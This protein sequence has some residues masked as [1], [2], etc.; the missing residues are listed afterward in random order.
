MRALAEGWPGRRLRAAGCCTTALGPPDGAARQAQQP[1]GT[2]L[3]RRRGRRA[4]LVP[5][6]AE[7]P[8][9]QPARRAG[10]VSPVERHRSAAR[11]GL[12]AGAAAR[13][14]PVPVRP[15]RAVR[16]GS[17]AGADRPVAAGESTAPPDHECLV[18]P[19]QVAILRS[20]AE[21]TSTQPPLWRECV[22]YGLQVD[23]LAV[24]R[25][26]ADDARRHPWTS[27]ED[28]SQR[29]TGSERSP[30]RAWPRRPRAP[31]P[32]LV[33][34]AQRG[35]QVPLD[36]DE[37]CRIDP[38]GPGGTG[39]E[40]CDVAPRSAATGCAGQLVAASAAAGV[41]RRLSLAQSVRAVRAGTRP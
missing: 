8:G 6:R 11:P 28:G 12:R 10:R 9:R 34:L 21:H 7:P 15:P 24:A 16:A 2:G 1:E 13:P 31:A 22:L 41:E 38:G 33:V 30:G 17:R 39:E 36:L 35:L 26:G 3:V 4:R 29:G 32:G 14:R 19:C 27:D 37:Q 18:H 40:V 20:Q 5:G 23:L 25:E